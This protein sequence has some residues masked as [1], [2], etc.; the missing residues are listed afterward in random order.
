[1][2]SQEFGNGKKS[3]I[4]DLIITSVSQMCSIMCIDDNIGGK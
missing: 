2:A 1:M 4:D 3:A